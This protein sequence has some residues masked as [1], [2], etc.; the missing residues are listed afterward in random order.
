VLDRLEDL[1]R[2]ARTQGTVDIRGG[3]GSPPRCP[4]GGGI[5]AAKPPLGRD[6]DMWTSF[7]I[8]RTGS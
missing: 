8:R 7:R 6:P 5:A 1:L 2:R 4:P 3:L